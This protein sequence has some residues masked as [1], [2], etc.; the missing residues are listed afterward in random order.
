MEVA[1]DRNGEFAPKLLHKYETSSNELEDKIV[2]LYA[3]GLSVRDIQANLQ[4]L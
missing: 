3:R 4:E 1:R 2:A